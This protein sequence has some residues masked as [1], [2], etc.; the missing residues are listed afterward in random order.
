MAKRQREWAKRARLA[1]VMSLGGKCVDCGSVEIARLELDHITPC[2]WDRSKT[3]AS[4]RI[5]IYRRE[6]KEGKITVRCDRCNASKSDKEAE[7]PRFA[8][9]PA[10]DGNG[11]GK[12]PL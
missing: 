4:M 9:A 6:I 1:M 10:I 2:T 3:D 8:P 11:N 12:H 7:Q 5:A